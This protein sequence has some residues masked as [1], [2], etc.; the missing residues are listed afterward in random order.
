[1]GAQRFKRSS[2]V[3]RRRRR[4]EELATPLKAIRN[5]CLECCGYQSQEVELCTDPMCWMY[6]YRFG[7]TP[8]RAAKAGKVVGLD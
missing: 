1:M 6:P 7:L 8:E 4:P 3:V 5:H 2:K